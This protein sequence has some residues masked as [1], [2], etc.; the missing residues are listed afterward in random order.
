MKIEDIIATS[1][2]IGQEI[3]RCGNI[4]NQEANNETISAS[5]YESIHQYLPDFIMY[6][7][8][9]EGVM[10]H[11]TFLYESVWNII[12]FAALLIIRRYNP[13][14]GHLFMYY[15]IMY[16]VGRFFIEGMRTDSLINAGLKQAQLISVAIIIGA[17]IV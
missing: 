8:C 2:I 9:I 7:M 4:I 5:T 12:V 15:L 14:R 13:I 1:L 11:P 6:Q 3:V 17:I 16:S 10:Y